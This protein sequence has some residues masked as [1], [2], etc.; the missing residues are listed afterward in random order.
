MTATD[1]NSAEL[2]PLSKNLYPNYRQPELVMVRGDG[3][4]MWDLSGKRYLDLYAGIAVNTLGHAHPAIVSAISDQAA[5]LMHVS[6]YYYTD[7]NLQLAE[8]LCRLAGMS[9]ALF[10]NSGTEAIE[11][12][13]KLSRRHFWNQ[14]DKNR[15]RV[16][17]FEKSFH[18][19]T[20]GA[21]TATGQAGYREGFGPIGGVTHVPFGDA[22]AVS[23]A[24]GPDVAAILVEPIQ[25]EGGVRP[26][27]DGFLATLRKLA[28]DHG[29]LLIFDEVQ[30]GVGRTGSFLAAHHFG[31]KADAVA[32]AKALGGGVPI[33][34]MLCQEKL[35]DALPPGSHGSTFG[36][37]PLCSAVAL[38]VLRTLEKDDL[39]GQ[40]KTKGEWLATKLTALQKKHPK[41]VAATRGIG[42]LQ[43][44]ELADTV[45]ARSVLGS[46]REK[47]LLLTL[48]GGQS[49]RFSP[50]LT[51]TTEQLGEGVDIVDQVLGELS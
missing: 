25:G 40:A 23:A 14:G 20:L 24:M 8:V 11:A 30:T 1:S 42:L 26:A 38:A 21:L 10:C 29:A 4:E 28:D 41:H 7:K 18:G 19:R 6:N 37:N 34:A 51:V 22:D 17:A 44:V 36:G 35:A 16:I 39:M 9:R 47:G 48:A 33:G 32:L 2:L 3:A 5:S 31:V 45:D 27:P 49:L 12:L 43:A 50:C 15:H 46:L 13:L